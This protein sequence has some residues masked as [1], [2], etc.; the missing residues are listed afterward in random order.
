MWNLEEQSC[1]QD[2]QQVQ[3]PE[4]E[5]SKRAIVLLADKQG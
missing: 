1:K 4:T 2:I 5:M 3:I